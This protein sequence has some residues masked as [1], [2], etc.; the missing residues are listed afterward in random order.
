[1]KRPV[2][3]P[4]LAGC[5]SL[6]FLAFVIK[7]VPGPAFPEE[8]EKTLK[9][10]CF[11]CHS[12]DASNKRAPVMLNFDKWDD[13]KVTKKISKLAAICEVVDGG[14]MPPAKF[15]KSNPDK[16]L[17]DSQKEMICDWAGEESDKLTEG[18]DE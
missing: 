17:S 16:A 7:P 14:K 13:Y 15:L 5:A 12:N 4:V 8:V 11:D 10:S 2:L 9:R 1:M 3:I 18:I 6:L